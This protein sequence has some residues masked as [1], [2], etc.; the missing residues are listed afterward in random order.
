M[1]SGRFYFDPD[2]LIYSSHFPSCPVVPGSVIIEGFVRVIK[3]FE[4]ALSRV[5]VKGFR[6]QS[7][8]TP[9]TYTYQMEKKSIHYD[10]RLMIDD[11]IMAK[12]VISC[13]A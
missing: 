3:Q 2:D 1:I 5:Q 4:P 11:K 7:F 8:V 13:E 9:G 6:F 10:C 12:G